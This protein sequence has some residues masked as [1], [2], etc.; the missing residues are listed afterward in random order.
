[1]ASFLIGAFRTAVRRIDAD[2]VLNIAFDALATG[3][4]KL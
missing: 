2:R 1:M 4:R 3:F